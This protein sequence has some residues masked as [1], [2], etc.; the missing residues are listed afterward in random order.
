MIL[1]SISGLFR[2]LLIIFG[3]LFLLQI[4]GKFA[5]ARRNIADQDQMKREEEAARKMRE[6][7]ARNFGKTTISKLDKNKLSDGDFVDFEEVKE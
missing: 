3:V 5:Q 4:F 7:S 2:T 6:N 1:L